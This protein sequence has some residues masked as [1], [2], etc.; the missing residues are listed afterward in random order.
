MVHEKLVL[1]IG[2]SRALGQRNK[3]KVDELKVIF[4]DFT[5]ESY[6]HLS[7]DVQIFNV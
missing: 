7:F 2:I 6:F 5:K 3:I 1:M 4:E